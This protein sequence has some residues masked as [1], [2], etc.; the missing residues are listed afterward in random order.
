MRPV[1][2]ADVKGQPKGV[3][4]SFDK[5]EID[6]ET[7]KATDLKLIVAAGDPALTVEGFDPLDVVYAEKDSK[8]YGASLVQPVNPGGTP[9]I[10]TYKLRLG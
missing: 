10:Y 6:G 9:L 7:I 1:I 2:A 8:R 4:T 3:L 5:E